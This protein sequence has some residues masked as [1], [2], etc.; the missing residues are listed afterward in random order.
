MDVLEIIEAHYDPGTPLYDLLIGHSRQVRD[1]ALAVARRVAHLAP[2]MRFIEE[3]AWLHD[4]GIRDTAAERIHCYGSLPYVCHGVVGGQMLNGCGLARHA[5]VCERHV[6]VGLS[7]SDILQQQLPLPLKD[8][9]PVTLEETI[10]CYAD[11]FFSKNRPDQELT[12]EDILIQLAPFGSA[13]VER[14][15]KWHFDFSGERIAPIDSANA[16]A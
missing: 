15:R 1:K 3:A 13:G 7:R 4:I 2:D 6:G 14:F 10:V 12:P 5:L 16:P 9:R 11:K 8:M